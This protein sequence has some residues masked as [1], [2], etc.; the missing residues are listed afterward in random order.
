MK[1]RHPF[2]KDKNLFVTLFSIVME[3]ANNGDLF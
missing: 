1:R 2:G 3:Y